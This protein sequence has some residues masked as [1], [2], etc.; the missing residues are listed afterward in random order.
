MFKFLPSKIGAERLFSTNCQFALLFLSLKDALLRW[1][2]TEVKQ[3]C[4]IVQICGFS[5]LSLYSKSQGDRKQ[6]WTK[7]FA[8]VALEHLQIA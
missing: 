2:A 1:F 4:F 7:I 3:F 5:D 8:I 6:A